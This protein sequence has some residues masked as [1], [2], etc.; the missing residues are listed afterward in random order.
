MEGVPSLAGQQALFVTNQLILMREGVRQ[1][2]QMT[3]V[4]KDLADSDIEALAAYYAGLVPARSSERL[5]PGSALRGAE[6]AAALGCGT[7]HLP[8]YSGQNQVPRL[9]KQRVDYLIAALTAYRD[10]RRIGSDTS[11]NAAMY[12]IRDADIAALAHFLAGR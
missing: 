12:G 11:M 1:I 3:A 5:D 8:D 4:V 9:A 10:N 7:C 2:E 6:A